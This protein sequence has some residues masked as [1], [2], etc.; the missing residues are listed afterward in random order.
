MR[1]TALTTS[2]AAFVLMLYLGTQPLR[3]PH[4]RHFAAPRPLPPPPGRLRVA[5]PAARSAPSG[6]SLQ[7][8]KE[9]KRSA[10]QTFRGLL[11]AAPK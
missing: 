4:A 6:L 2:V 10:R 7:E 1:R 3:P 5:A 8:K 9:R 11:S